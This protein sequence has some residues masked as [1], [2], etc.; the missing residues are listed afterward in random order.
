MNVRLAA[1]GSVFFAWSVAR[2]SKLWGPFE[3]GLA[4]VWLAPGPEHAANGWESKRHAK[5]E[6]DSL[7]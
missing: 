5:V 4:G 6:F 3:S 2:T 1:V 7:D